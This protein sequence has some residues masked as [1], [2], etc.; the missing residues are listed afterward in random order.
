MNSFHNPTTSL[1]GRHAAAVLTAWV[2]RDSLSLAAELDRSANV[3][4]AWRD[5]GEEEQVELLQTVALRMKAWPD[6]FA[7]RS[8]DRQLG[9]CVTLLTHLAA[10]PVCFA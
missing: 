5:G 10:A 2:A 8:A 4:A 9:I 6:P 7:V 1:A 3:S